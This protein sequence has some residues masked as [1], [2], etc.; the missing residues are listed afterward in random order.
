[1]KAK[2]MCLVV[3]L[4]NIITLPTVRMMYLEVFLCK[5]LMHTC[6]HSLCQKIRQNGINQLVILLFFFF[7]F[8]PGF[9]VGINLFK[10]NRE[11]A[12]Q[13]AKNTNDLLKNVNSSNGTLAKDDLADED[14]NLMIKLKFL[15]YKVCV[16]DDLLVILICKYLVEF[17]PFY[18]VVQ[19][20]IYLY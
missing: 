12:A 10:E 13:T 20:L 7:F 14:A 9:F 19:F 17:H 3:I 5:I 2:P 11:K 18:C 6:T 4:E 15:T 1:M 8:L 16:G